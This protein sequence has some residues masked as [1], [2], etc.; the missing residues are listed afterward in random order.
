[1]TDEGLE[2]EHKSL[3]YAL[4]QH[5]DARSLSHDCVGFANAAGGVILL[6]VENGAD[7]PP[8]GQRVEEGLSAKINKRIPQITVN[9]AVV[10]TKRTAGN[11]GEYIEIR[12]RGNQQSVASTSDGR[13]FIR[14]SDETQPLRGDELPRLMA[15]RSS[16]VWELQPVRGLDVDQI[17][18]QKISAFREAVRAS[19]RVSD[20][21]KTMSDREL[22]EHY[23][24]VRD[25]SL[26]H[27]GVLWVGL[28]ADRAALLYAPAI[29]CIKFDA[30]GKKIRKFA[31]DDYNLSPLELI[32]AVWDEVPDWR[33]TYELP[34]GLFRKSVPH[35]DEVVVRELL[36]NALVHRPYTQ[37]GDIFVN[38]YPDRLEVHNPGLLPIGVT[39]QNILHTTSQRNRHLA[40]VFYDLKLMEGEGSGFNRMYEALLSSGRPAP[41]VWEGDDRVVVM[42]QKRIARPEVIDLMAKVDRTFQP[43]QKELITLGAIAQHESLRAAELSKALSLRSPEE[44]A[45][46]MGQLRYWGLVASR[47]RTKATE[48]YVRPDVLRRLQFKGQTSL[49]GIEKQRLRELLLRDLGIY[50]E[51]AIGQIHPR[52][53]SEIPRRSVQRVLAELVE[54]GLIRAE[55]ERRGRKYLFVPEQ[56][57][58]GQSGA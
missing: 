44:L 38:L 50:R 46:W 3:R 53:G 47:G 18:A 27:L 8:A 58:S 28:R 6:G 37:R 49:K 55:G 36:A 19:D 54:E 31:W 5:R 29:Q 35:Y 24:F 39:P 42:V 10:A 14:V 41:S 20:F 22:L 7:A 16:F 15:D 1:M 56:G 30:Q 11:G 48:Y 57:E 26:T 52:I 17:D 9:V 2:H 32:A 43:S 4:D 21:I 13:F 45:E 25:G 12:G 23:F 33:E 51:A 40:K 34:A